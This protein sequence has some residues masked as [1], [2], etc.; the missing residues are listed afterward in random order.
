MKTK[1]I[2]LILLSF[3][4]I[5]FSIYALDRW[6]IRHKKDIRDVPYSH[7]EGYGHKEVIYFDKIFLIKPYEPINTRDLIT[8][9]FLILTGI[10]SLITYFILRN[11]PHKVNHKSLWLLFSVG[12]LYLGFD[13]MLLFH[14]FMG[15]NFAHL[16]YNNYP[17]DNILDKDFNGLIILVYAVL[18]L[19]V[20]AVRFS[21]FK[22]NR[23][24][25]LL[26]TIGLMFQGA[27]AIIDYL[28]SNLH[29]LQNLLGPLELLVFRDEF[30][31]MNASALYFS[32]FTLYSLTNISEHYQ[33]RDGNYVLR[34][35][36]KCE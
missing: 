12:F 21:F 28:W 11:I 1:K 10:S 18:A 26:L 3:Y 4:L 31:E 19:I 5:A 22:K 25:L 36:E 7:A 27:A 24:A 2:L 17:L 8:S 33:N 32:A 23:M 14:E 15:L 34:C 13:E 35:L 20:L 16:F 30:F 6:L 9:A 29:V